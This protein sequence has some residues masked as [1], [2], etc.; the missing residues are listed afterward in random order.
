MD[1]IQRLYEFSLLSRLDLRSM[2]QSLVTAI[3]PWP[4]AVTSEYTGD[5]LLIDSKALPSV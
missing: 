3:A 1:K 2:S 4:I 5:D